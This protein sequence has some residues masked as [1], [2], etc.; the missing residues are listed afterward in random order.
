MS[1]CVSVTAL[2]R[3]ATPL[4]SSQRRVERGAHRGIGFIEKGVGRI[5]VDGADDRPARSGAV[6][7]PRRRN[8]L[9]DHLADAFTF[10]PRAPLYPRDVVDVQRNGD[11]SSCHRGV[12]YHI[13]LI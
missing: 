7:L 12:S 8:E 11:G 10:G 9:I 3:L 13:R 1:G 4:R 5:D 6:T 2:W